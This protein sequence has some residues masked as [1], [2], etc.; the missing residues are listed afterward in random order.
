MRP[1]TA[2]ALKRLRK[3]SRISGRRD[4]LFPAS[5]LTPSRLRVATTMPETSFFS[6]EKNISIFFVGDVN[7]TAKKYSSF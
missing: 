3:S 5:S 1:K 2:A 6:L 4:A 7:V